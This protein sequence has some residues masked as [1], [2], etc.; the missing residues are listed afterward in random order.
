[1]K[2]TPVSVTTALVAIPMMTAAGPAVSTSDRTLVVC[3]SGR[4]F[5]LKAPDVMG[6]VYRWDE[7]PPIPGCDAAPE[8]EAFEPPAAEPPGGMLQ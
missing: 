5:A 1:M 3:R 4:V 8:A 7:L 6:G 2:D